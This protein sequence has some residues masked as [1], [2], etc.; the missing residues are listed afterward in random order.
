[1]R[2][3]F[4]AGMGHV[5]TIT[6]ELLT[7]AGHEVL[8][9]DIRDRSDYPAD[10]AASADFAIV[11]VN[12]PRAES[13]EA[14]LSQVH[15]ALEALPAGPHAVLRS[16]MP[17]GTSQQ[18]ATAY[19]RPVTFWPEY[20]G[21]TQFAAR[22]WSGFVPAFVVLGGEPGC[23]GTRAFAD[24][25]AEAYGPEAPFHLLS[26][27]EA[28]CV[29]YMENTFF[30]LKVAFVN[31]WRAAVESIGGDWHRVREAW[32]QD[33]RIGRDHSQAFRSAP[34]FEGRCLPKDL[35]AVLQ[36][37]LRN[38]VDLPLLWA[39]RESNQSALGARQAYTVTRRITGAD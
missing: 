28:E 17:P 14:D 26:L 4:I 7:C 9:Y 13:G 2:R 1:M 20:I 32:L 23:S 6:A 21:E 10:F 37:S 30:A 39:V 19:D 31:E 34:G 38:N 35:D 22:R 8:G 33:P 27:D 29:K 12:T 16:T 3:I 5:G 18:I 25:L 11:C 24:L 36:W 15:A